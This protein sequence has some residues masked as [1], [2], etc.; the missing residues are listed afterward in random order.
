LPFVVATIDGN[1]RVLEGCSLSDREQAE[2]SKVRNAVGS[3]AQQREM[4]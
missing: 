3:I 4:A 2:S 1:Q